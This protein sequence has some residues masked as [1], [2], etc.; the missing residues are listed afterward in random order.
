[1]K[2]TVGERRLPGKGSQGYSLNVYTCGDTVG[3][4]MRTERWGWGKREIETHESWINHCLVYCSSMFGFWLIA[5]HFI[6]CL[7]V[8]L[9]TYSTSYEKDSELSYERT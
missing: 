5:L 4:A 6:A 1:M 9:C 2:C 7:L 3:P 8:C